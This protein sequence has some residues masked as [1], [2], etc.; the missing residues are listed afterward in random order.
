LDLVDKYWAVKTGDE[1][2][3]VLQCGLQCQVV[4]ECQRPH[5]MIGCSDLGA[6]RRL[7]YLPGAGD[8]HD[9]RVLRSRRTRRQIDGGPVAG[10]PRVKESVGDGSSPAS[11]IL[12]GMSTSFPT[13]SMAV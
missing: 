7:A 5:R 13:A 9:P 4:V 3:R 2:G 11:D 6:Q 1:A 12:G 8:E 10:E